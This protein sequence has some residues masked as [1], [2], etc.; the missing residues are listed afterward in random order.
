MK[1]PEWQLGVSRP[2]KHIR[3]KKV[4]RLCYFRN[5]RATLIMAGLFHIEET[6]HRLPYNRF[7]L[8]TRPCLFIPKEWPGRLIFP[9]VNRFLSLGTHFAAIQQKRPLKEPLVI[10]KA[11]CFIEKAPAIHDR[12]PVKS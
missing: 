12:H 2:V 1:Y 9:P 4:R 5:L 10:R 11:F 3:L 7:L 6:D 8:A